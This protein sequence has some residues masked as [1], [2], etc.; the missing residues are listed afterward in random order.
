M[1]YIIQ[2]SSML[3]IDGI[4]LSQI[5]GSL[6]IPMIEKIQKEKFEINY[7][8]T[9]FCYILLNIALYKFIIIERRHPINA[10]IL[11]FCIYGVFD[12]TNYAIFNNYE[13]VPSIIDSIW[14]GCLFY[15]VTMIIYKMLKVKY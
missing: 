3:I 11:G 4:Y 15:I 14:G 10:F 7:N 13:L 9:I 1:D 5:G 12:S 6:F 2:I 8:A